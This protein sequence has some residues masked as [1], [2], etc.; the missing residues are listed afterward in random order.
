MPPHRDYQHQVLRCMLL[1]P[2]MLINAIQFVL[3]WWIPNFLMILAISVWVAVIRLCSVFARG[4]T[5]THVM[6]AVSIVWFA[7]ITFCCIYVYG[8]L[9]GV[10]WIIAMA[11]GLLIAAFLIAPWD[12]I[13]EEGWCGFLNSIVWKITHTR[14]PFWIW[15]AIWM[16]HCGA[17]LV[18]TIICIPTTLL[19]P[20]TGAWVNSLEPSQVSSIAWNKDQLVPFVTYWG[21]IFFLV[22]TLLHVSIYSSILHFN[23]SYP[24]LAMFGLQLISVGTGVVAW[25]ILYV[26][27]LQYISV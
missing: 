14:N 17:I 24:P 25:S 4:Q 7:S 22:P 2:L 15:A 26:L 20:I 8:E 6:L 18:V 10:A 3:C 23:T 27:Y 12:S 19:Y 9:Y 13:M 16:F 11:M 1:C 5:I 21:S